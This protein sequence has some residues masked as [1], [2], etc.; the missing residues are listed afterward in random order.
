MRHRRT[1]TKTFSAIMNSNN[2]VS[3]ADVSGGGAGRTT[4][5]R[6]GGGATAYSV[7]LPLANVTLQGNAMTTLYTGNTTANITVADI[8]QFHTLV[9]VAWANTFASGQRIVN[10][11]PRTVFDTLTTLGT[12]HLSMTGS[13]GT[14]TRW[15]DVYKISNTSVGVANA[16]NMG[17]TEIYGIK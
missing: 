6:Q 14:T 7:V 12:R 3:F 11:I 17:M 8:S 9:F 10:T 16:N 4:L 13:N 2:G 5:S 1:G 15:L